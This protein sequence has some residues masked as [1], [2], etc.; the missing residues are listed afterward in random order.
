MQILFKVHQFIHKILNGNE[1]L[2][3]NK[4]HNQVTNLRKLTCNNPNVDQVKVNT[5]TKFGLISSLRS[6]DIER[7]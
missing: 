3:T 5:Y 2:T 1:I 7:K 6:Q 4:G